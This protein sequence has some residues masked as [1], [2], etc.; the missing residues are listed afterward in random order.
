MPDPLLDESD[1][2]KAFNLGRIVQI[3]FV[4]RDLKASLPYYTAI[5]GPFVT[6]HADVDA[7]KLSYR[8]SPAASTLNIG[9][10]SSGDVEI[11]LI[12]VESGDHPVDEHLR[13]HGDGIH[14]VS[15]QVEDVASKMGELM[16]AGF[17]VLMEGGP[18]NGLR[19]CHLQNQAHLGHTVI[20]LIQ[21]APDSAID[22]GR[23]R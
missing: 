21:V 15:F 7:E 8:G 6:A 5:F 19:F 4:V 23:A 16:H 12:E 13:D 9:F 18:A 11:E 20:E 10:G 14:H 1:V 2:L 17:A 22:A 3:G